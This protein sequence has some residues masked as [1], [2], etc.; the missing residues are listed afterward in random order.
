MSV[1]LLATVD[2]NN[3][4][5]L[6]IDFEALLKLSKDNCLIIEDVLFDYLGTDLPDRETIVVGEP[7]RITATAV[8]V[9]TVHDAIE[10]FTNSKHERTAIV[11]HSM[12][13]NLL[14]ACKSQ[15]AYVRTLTDHKFKRKSD[16]DAQ[17]VRF[18]SAAW[19]VM[20]RGNNKEHPSAR[21]MSVDV[22]HYERLNR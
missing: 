7:T 13:F 3:C 21:Y 20:H 19:K 14:A 1:H 22:A 16:D 18:N 11:G 10:Y 12:G 8:I 9:P 4:S 15:F 5:L 17:F 6:D 2:S